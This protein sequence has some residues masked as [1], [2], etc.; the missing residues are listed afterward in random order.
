M[1]KSVSTALGQ[2]CRDAGIFSPPS[3]PKPGLKTSAIA[4]TSDR[5]PSLE[6]HL[7]RDVANDT[8]SCAYCGPTTVAAIT[9]APVSLVR[10]AYRFVRYGSNWV[11][12]PRAP[13]I[14]G[15]YWHETEKVLR[16]LGFVG[17]WH[18]VDGSPTFAAFMEARTGV[19]RTHPCALFVT[20]HVVAVS[21][22]QFCDTFSKGVVVEADD[23][24]R[25]RTRVKRVFVITGRVPPSTIPR[26]DYSAAKARAAAG[27][28]AR[29]AFTRYLAGLG[30]RHELDRDDESIIV[31]FADGR[32]VGMHFDDWKQALGDLKEYLDDP[33]ED[34]IEEIERGFHWYGS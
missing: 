16:L 9:G 11:N 6:G 23:A 19:M 4:M 24:P 31:S 20:R 12:R 5:R 17:T 14:A 2:S 13:V 8:G 25:R 29:G 1:F 7:L 21:G 18:T 15:T 32:K 10:D 30:A 26:K 28:K 33:Q 3:A 22:W 27:Q 34:Q